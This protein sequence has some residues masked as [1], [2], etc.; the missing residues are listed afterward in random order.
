MKSTKQKLLLGQIV[1]NSNIRY[2]G[3]KAHSAQQIINEIKK[4]SKE[5]IKLLTPPKHY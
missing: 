4:V 1:E 5:E 2:I 3:N